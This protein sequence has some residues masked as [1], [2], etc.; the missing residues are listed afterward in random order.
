MN[1]NT[2]DPSI[3]Q[4]I[5]ELSKHPD[6]LEKLTQSI[7]PGIIGHDEIKQALLLHLVG[8]VPKDRLSRGAIHVL[9]IGDPGTGKQISTVYCLNGLGL[10]EEQ[11]PGC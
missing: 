4:R 2:P 10:T 11:L 9:L 1:P 6:L 3:L 7:A 8:G 5:V